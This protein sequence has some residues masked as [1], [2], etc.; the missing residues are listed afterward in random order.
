MPTP[1]ERFLKIVRD[2]GKKNRSMLAANVRL[3][4]RVVA[5]QGPDK[6]SIDPLSGARVV[7]NMAAVHVPAFCKSTYQNT[8]GRAT[9]LG[10]ACAAPVSVRVFV[11]GMLE[12]IPGAP[13]RTNLYFGA[14]ELNGTG[15]RFYGD[16]CLVLKADHIDASTPVLEANS[17]DLVRPPLTRRGVKLDNAQKAVLEDKLK[18]MYCTWGA[19]LTRLV[20]L[21]VSASRDMSQRRLT[22]GQISELVLS[23]EDYLEVLMGKTFTAGEL[24]AA[25]LSPAD[26]AA[27]THIGEQLRSGPAPTIAELEWR[28]HRRAAVRALRKRQ[29]PIAVSTTSGRVRT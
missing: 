23:D 21:K 2:I 1:A 17:Y 12:S 6:D 10:T 5:G 26:A 24:Q 9:T 29:V 25:R 13:H 14:L 16:I 19:G 3:I 27:E 4:A 7:V 15:I 20:A 11:D 22:T 8:Y 28:K 18:D